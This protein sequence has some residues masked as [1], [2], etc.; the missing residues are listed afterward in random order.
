MLPIIFFAC[1]LLILGLLIVGWNRAVRNDLSSKTEKNELFIS[2][3]IP[4][5]N[6]GHNIKYLLADLESQDH[7]DFEVIVVDDHSEDNTIQ[8]VQDVTIRN[9]RFRIIYNAGEGK[10]TALTSGIEA[11]KGTIIITTDADCRVSAEWISTIARYFNKQEIKMVFGCVRMDANS[12]FSSLQSLEFASLIGS[13]VSMASWKYPIM[14]NGANLA[15]RKSVFGDVGGYKGNLHIPSGDDEFLMRKILA[16]YPNG[17]KPVL[18]LQTVVSTLPNNTLKEFFQQRIRWAGKWT[19]NTSRL[20]R[21]L[22]S[23]VF[24]FHLTTILL[25][26]FVAFDWI[27]IQTFLILTL[28]KASLEFLF[29]NRVT[30]FLSMRWNWVAFVLLQLIYPLYVVFI[31]VLSN[32]NS[33]E[34]KGRK[35]KSLTVSNKLNKQVLG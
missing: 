34:W 28:S 21:L 26:L 19:A 20:S 12:I 32:F 27:D 14:C 7:A 4:V 23:F 25:P 18:G 30:R 5:R 6:E 29:L 8:L 17:I 24:C 13:G 1:Y 10:K 33:F 11:A 15:F 3:V 2:V 22:A 9:P 31:G 16:V 35:L